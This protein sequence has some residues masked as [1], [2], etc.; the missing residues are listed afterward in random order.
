MD[1]FSIS[2]EKNMIHCIVDYS[3]IRVYQANNEWNGNYGGLISQKGIRSKVKIKFITFFTFIILMVVASKVA[4]LC[5]L[6]KTQLD[7]MLIHFGGEK[8][9]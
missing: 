1:R 3:N 9:T 6:L 5:E 7:M 2:W 8:T 4:N